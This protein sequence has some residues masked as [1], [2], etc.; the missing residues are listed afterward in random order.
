MKGKHMN[1]DD[2]PLRVDRNCPLCGHEATFLPTEFGS[3]REFDCPQC[4][5]FLISAGIEDRIMNSPKSFREKLSRKAIN[6]PQKMMLHIY[7]VNDK[8][9]ANYKPIRN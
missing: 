6:T 3:K 2:N 5:T 8:I 1:H 4:K 7:I 9:T